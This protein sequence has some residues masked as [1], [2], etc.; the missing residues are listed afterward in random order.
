MS[1]VFI[2]VAFVA[3]VLVGREKFQVV[4]SVVEKVSTKFK[5]VLDKASK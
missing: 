2:V 1:I 4:E 3:G 5:E